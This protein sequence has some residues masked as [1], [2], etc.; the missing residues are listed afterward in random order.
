MLLALR[1]FQRALLRGMQAVRVAQVL[2]VLAD[3]EHLWRNRQVGRK[4]SEDVLAYL[5]QLTALVNA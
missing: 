3:D 1:S 5:N 4:R 2:Q